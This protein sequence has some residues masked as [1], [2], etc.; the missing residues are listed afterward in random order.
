MKFSS[1]AANSRFACDLHSHKLVL[2]RNTGGRDEEL[3]NMTCAKTLAGSF[4]YLTTRHT[5]N[6]ATRERG[7]L[8]MPETAKK[9]EKQK[10]DEK[11]VF[12]VDELVECDYEDKNFFW[13]CT[14]I[15]INENGRDI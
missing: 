8:L 12:K 11:T 4:V 13:P 1:I 14:V 7:R 9:K 10:M 3:N 6:K 15:K 2:F 5:W